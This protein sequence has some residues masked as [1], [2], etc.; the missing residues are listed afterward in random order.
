MFHATQGRAPD[1]CPNVRQVLRLYRKKR[2][3]RIAAP[4]SLGCRARVAVRTTCD[5]RYAF[6]CSG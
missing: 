6:G 5:R 4:V 3:R 2:N 1:L